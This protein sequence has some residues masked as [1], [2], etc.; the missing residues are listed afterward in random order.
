MRQAAILATERGLRVCAPVHD[1]FLIEA[2]RTKIE[3]VVVEMQKAMREASRVVLDGLELR[4]DVK[5]V[6]SPDRYM[7][8]RGTKMWGTVMSLINEDDGRNG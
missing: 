8:E 4:S 7:D 5:Y 3:V 6:H 2:P 1:A